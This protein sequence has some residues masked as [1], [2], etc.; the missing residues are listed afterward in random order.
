MMKELLTAQVECQLADIHNA[1]YQE[2]GAAVDMIK[3]LA[4]TIYYCTVTEAMKEKEE[5]G[6]EAGERYYSQR[7]YPRYPKEE[8][9]Y[10]REPMMMYYDGRGGNSG[11]NGGNTSS[12]GG[13]NNGG[14]NNS[15]GSNSGSSGGRYYSER[16]YPFGLHDERE[17]RSPAKRRRYMESKEAH[18]EESARMKELESYMQD[19]AT[20]IAEMIK[21]ASLSEKQLLQKK[22]S[23]LATKVEQL[24]A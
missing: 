7:K 22:I 8:W 16:E 11:G 3:D 21:D 20:D 6:E 5:E 9:G 23:S 12:G 1:D 18:S 13:G 24:N 2:L 4:E 19:L 15:S 10:E 17:G 14:G